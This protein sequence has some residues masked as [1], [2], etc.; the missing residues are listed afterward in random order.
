VGVGWDIFVRDLKFIHGKA[1]GGTEI[2]GMKVLP[3]SHFF[4]TGRDMRMF[5]PE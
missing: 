4:S 2:Y 1:A 3:V 5:Y